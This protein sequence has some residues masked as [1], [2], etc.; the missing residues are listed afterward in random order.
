MVKHWDEN[1]EVTVSSNDIT[2]KL[3][4]DGNVIC[5]DNYP[6]L[7]EYDKVFRTL[8]IGCTTVEIGVLNRLLY[9]VEH[10]KHIGVVQLQEGSR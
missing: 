3:T 5:R 1:G 2:H 7:V 6:V 4:L 8:R 10:G 9:L